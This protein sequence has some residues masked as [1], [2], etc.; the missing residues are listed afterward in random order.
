MSNYDTYNTRSENYTTY[1]TEL[2]NDFLQ[3]VVSI[4]FS[5]ECSLKKTPEIEIVFISDLV[6]IARA[7]YLEQPKSMLRLKLLN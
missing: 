5:N 1:T 4:Y 7:H 2:A 3:R 6:N